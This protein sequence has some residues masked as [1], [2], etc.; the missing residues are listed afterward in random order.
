MSAASPAG[1]LHTRRERGAVLIPRPMLATHSAMSPGRILVGAQSCCAR[2]AVEIPFR[3]QHDCAP[4]HKTTSADAYG[5]DMV[6]N[7]RLWIHLRRG[8]EMS[9]PYALTPA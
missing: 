4:T 6:R 1:I 8:Y 7:N 9:G 3:A 2:I 5:P